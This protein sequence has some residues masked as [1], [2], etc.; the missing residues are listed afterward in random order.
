MKRELLYVLPG[1]TLDDPSA[2][3]ERYIERAEKRGDEVF[4]IQ[5]KDGFI[6][7][8]RF[9]H[10]NTDGTKDIVSKSYLKED[11]LTPKEAA[12]AML[13]GEKLVDFIQTP[14]IAQYRLNGENFV[15]YDSYEFDSAEA[16]T[17]F[18]GLR[19][20]VVDDKADAEREKIRV[21]EILGFELDLSGLPMIKRQYSLK[22]AMTQAISMCEANHWEITEE[23]VYS[24]LANLDSDLESMF[25]N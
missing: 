6:V 9:Y 21:K 12:E 8:E 23:H 10:H 20:R 7:Y 22:G 15:V 4:Q 24:V 16:I 17:S 18:T 14:D 3:L 25:G 11:E 2:T 13:A 5:T 1:E 19:H